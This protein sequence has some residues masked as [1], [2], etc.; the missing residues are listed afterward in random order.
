MLSRKEGGLE[1]QDM[2]LTFGE[3]AVSAAGTKT[4]GTTAAATDGV[5]VATEKTSLEGMAVVIN[6]KEAAAGGT[7]KFELLAKSGDS[8]VTIAATEALATTALAKNT[9]VM[10]PIPRGHAGNNGVDAD[11]QYKLQV[12]SGT[13]TTAGTFYAYVDTHMG[14]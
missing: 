7:Q 3:I 4:F 13:G 6:V 2:M 14:V 10:L 11:I 5:I 9:A 1:R 8:W 12:V